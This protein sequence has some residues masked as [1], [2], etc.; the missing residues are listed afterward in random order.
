VELY[1]LLLAVKPS[2][3]VAMN[4]AIAVAEV[5]GAQAGLDALAAIRPRKLLET[6]YLYPGTLGE[7]Y[8]RLGDH[9]AAARHPRRAVAMAT[10]PAEQ[11]FLEQKLRSVGG[12]QTMRATG[13]S[14]SSAG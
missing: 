5:H 4:R 10:S 14:R 1:D 11:R 6:Y 8:I 7:L 13:P 9:A 12:G 2:P 3:I